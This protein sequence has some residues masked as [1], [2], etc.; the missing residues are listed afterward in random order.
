M[1]RNTLGGL[2]KMEGGSKSLKL[3]RGR[4]DQKVLG[5]QWGGGSNPGSKKIPKPVGQSGDFFAKM[6]NA[7]EISLAFL[8]IFAQSFLYKKRKRKIGKLEKAVRW[9]R[10]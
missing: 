3:P 8:Q 10:T 4:G 6:T 5:T 1:F 9:A 7:K 2:G